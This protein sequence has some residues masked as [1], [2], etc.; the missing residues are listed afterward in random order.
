MLALYAPVLTPS[1]GSSY[2]LW[3]A[4]LV[5][6]G[7]AGFAAVALNWRQSSAGLDTVAR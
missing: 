4:L 5:A 7:L 3:A 6:V 1:P 2:S